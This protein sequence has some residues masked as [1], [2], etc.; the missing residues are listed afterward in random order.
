MFNK[1]LSITSIAKIV[2]DGITIIDFIIR[3]FIKKIEINERHNKQIKVAK[4]CKNF[5]MFDWVTDKT[6]VVV[7]LKKS[8]LL[9]E[10]EF[11]NN[12]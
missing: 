5:K 12:I 9:S 10:N 2:S 4:F 3:F 6:E 11:S 8:V 7:Y 1:Q